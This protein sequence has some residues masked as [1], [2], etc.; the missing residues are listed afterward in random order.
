M[1]YSA[2]IDLWQEKYPI[3]KGLLL[4]ENFQEPGLKLIFSNLR[5]HLEKKFFKPIFP[6]T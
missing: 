4:Y 2:A 1:K 3:I 6:E 5:L